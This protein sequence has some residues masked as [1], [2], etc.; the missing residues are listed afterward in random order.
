MYGDRRNTDF[1]TGLHKLIHLAEAN[2]HDGFMPCP[3]VD[4]RNVKE[5]SS[6]R[7]LHAHLLRRGFMPSYNCW[8]KHGERGVMIEDNEEEEDDDSYPISPEGNGDTA[9][10]NN[11]E[12]RG[13]K[14]TS[15][16]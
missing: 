7:I 2:K 10:E 12:E 11:E 9:M 3:C 16:R 1:I 15:I 13:D 4:C 8:T 14:Q 6:S 5:Y